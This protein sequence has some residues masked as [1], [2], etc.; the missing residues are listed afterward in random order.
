MLRL[1]ET[2]EMVGAAR[3]GKPHHERE[4][5]ERSGHSAQPDHPPAEQGPGV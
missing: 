5:E 3:A 1:G 4:P 2:G